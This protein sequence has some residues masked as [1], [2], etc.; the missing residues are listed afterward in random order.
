[1]VAKATHFNC[2]L[3]MFSVFFEVLQLQAMHPCLLVEVEQHLQ[4]KGEEEG[5]KEERER[6]QEREER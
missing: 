2:L 5:E 1:M 6:E 3:V 4:G